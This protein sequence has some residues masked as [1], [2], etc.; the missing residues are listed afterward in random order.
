MK[1]ICL[2]A[3]ALA[4]LILAVFLIQRSHAAEQ[5]S[6]QTHEY[7]TIRWGGRENT[8]LIRP[9]GQVEMLGPLLQNLKRPDRVDERTYLMNLALNA[10]AKEG[11][12]LT[13][14]TADEMVLRRAISR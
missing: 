13:S 9:N 14:M 10:V 12:E 11:F 8:H 6:F 3:A 1:K 4:A 2:S 7:A 5:R